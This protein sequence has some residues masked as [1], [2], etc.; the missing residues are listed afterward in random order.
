MWDKGI[1]ETGLQTSF[2]WLLEM[3]EVD[4]GPILWEKSVMTLF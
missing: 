2:K 3:L 1:F 4:K